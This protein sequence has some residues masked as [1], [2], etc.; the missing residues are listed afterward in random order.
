MGWLAELSADLR[1][2]VDIRGVFTTMHYTNGHFRMEQGYCGARRRKWRLADTDRCPCGET[3]M[4]SNIVKFLSS[5]KAEW[6]LI[7]TALCRT[8]RCFLADQLWFTTHM[9]KEEEV[10]P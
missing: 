5:D 1:E 10:C 3:Q 9:P 4:M 7:S 6:Q 2:A 8:R